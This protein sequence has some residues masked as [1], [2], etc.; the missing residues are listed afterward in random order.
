MGREFDDGRYLAC[1]QVTLAQILHIQD[2]GLHLFV[3]G[4]S[5]SGLCARVV[6][7]SEPDRLNVLASEEELS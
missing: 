6:D 3:K 7:V 1:H 4:N 2:C 5:V